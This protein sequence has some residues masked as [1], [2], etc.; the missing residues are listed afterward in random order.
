M[1]VAR[2]RLRQAFIDADIGISG[3]NV[4]IADSGTL[5]IVSNEGNGR[6]VTTL[7]PVH[8]RLLGIEKIVPTLEDATA[9]L[10]VL[11]RFRHRPEDHELRFVRHRTEPKC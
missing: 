2:Q 7:P 9:I 6:L 1:K 8:I 10:Q 5:V 11:P 4:A 3:A